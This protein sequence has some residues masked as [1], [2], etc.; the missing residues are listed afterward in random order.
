MIYHRFGSPVQI[1]GNCGMFKR[2]EF[3]GEPIVNNLV[4]IQF[5]N[6]SG[7]FGYAWA[8]FLRADDG[9]QEIKLAIDVAPQKPMTVESAAVA[10]KDAE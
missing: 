6:G 7:K 5:D 8:E 9:W 1:I 3:E 4:Y 2:D 10:F